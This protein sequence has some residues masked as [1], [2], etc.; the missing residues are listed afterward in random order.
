MFFP[1]SPRG[2]LI[3]DHP[4]GWPKRHGSVFWALWTNLI[5]WTSKTESDYQ[6]PCIALR[7]QLL[8]S[9]APL[10]RIACWR[11]TQ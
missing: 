1:Q 8:E 11:H 4:V 3:S 6:I 7:P 5:S 2:T 10:I 9:S